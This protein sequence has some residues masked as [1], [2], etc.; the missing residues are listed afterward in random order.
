MYYS[1][2]VLKILGITSKIYSKMPQIVHKIYPN[3][4]KKI[5]QYFLKIDS[6]CLSDNPNNF[7]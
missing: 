7:F 1:N 3:S 4:A 6:R 2:N 5:S